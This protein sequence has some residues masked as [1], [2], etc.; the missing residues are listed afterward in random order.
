M[1][2][3]YVGESRYEVVLSQNSK[4]VPGDSFVTGCFIKEQPLYL[5]YIERSICP[6][7]SALT[8]ARRPLWQAATAD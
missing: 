5:P 4:L 1:R 6:T 2:L 7:S 8:A 3:R